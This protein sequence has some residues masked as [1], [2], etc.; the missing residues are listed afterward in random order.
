MV[1][2][3]S[4]ITQIATTVKNWCHNKHWVQAAKY[5]QIYE[6]IQNKTGNTYY[7]IVTDTNAYYKDICNYSIICKL[8]VS[9]MKFESK[10]KLNIS[11][12]S[13][14][15]SNT[16]IMAVETKMCTVL[17]NEYNLQL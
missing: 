12:T 8:H 16:T 5:L 15:S 11:H 17:T 2:C 4:E 1:Q 7:L 6:S 14:L 10:Q 13:S 3:K 9:H